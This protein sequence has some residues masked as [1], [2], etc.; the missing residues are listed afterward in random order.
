MISDLK[1]YLKLQCVT[2]FKYL[3]RNALQKLYCV[4]VDWILYYSLRSSSPDFHMAWCYHLFSY[5]KSF[6]F[7]FVQVEEVGVI[8]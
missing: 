6:S 2:F 3:N 1:S 5:L 4:E 8:L 7:Y